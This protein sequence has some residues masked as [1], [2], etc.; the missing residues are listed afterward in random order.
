[1]G[2][3][4]ELNTEQ[5]HVGRAFH[6]QSRIVRATRWWKEEG[7]MTRSLSLLAALLCA[8]GGASMAQDTAAT[9]QSSAAAKQFVEQAGVSGL[10]E[11][12][13]GELGAKKATNGQVKAFAKRIVTD[14]TKANE[15]LLTAIKGKGLQVPSSRTSMH[16]ATVERLQQQDA[17]KNFDREY[18]QQMIEHHKADIELFETAA[19]DEKLDLVLRGYAKRTLPTLREHLE[20][21]Q[22]IQSKL[23]G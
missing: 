15:E 6:Y 10:S 11:I 21:A 3:N 4:D 13:M 17:G 8:T 23:T 22:T 2:P 14:H 1:M 16:K 9:A 12:E 20:E 7:I 19:D 5:A 18:M